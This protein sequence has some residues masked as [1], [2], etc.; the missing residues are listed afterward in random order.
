MAMVA[1]IV[2][3][4]GTPDSGE[5]SAGFHVPDSWE[6]ELDGGLFDAE[7]NAIP[8]PITSSGYS[9]TTLTP[10]FPHACPTLARRWAHTSRPDEVWRKNSGVLEF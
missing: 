10:L 6:W 3:V 8:R 4:A 9:R 2:V 1:P 5:T 7:D